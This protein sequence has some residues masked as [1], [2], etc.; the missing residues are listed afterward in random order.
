[1]IFGATPFGFRSK[2]LHP[3][4]ALSGAATDESCYLINHHNFQ[5]ESKTSQTMYISSMPAA[6]KVGFLDSALPIRVFQARFD[7]RMGSP[8]CG[9]SRQA[10][11]SND[12]FLG[13]EPQRPFYPEV[14]KL[15][16][17]GVHRERLAVGRDFFGFDFMTGFGGTFCVFVNP[18]LSNPQ[19]E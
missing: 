7:A 19:L 8:Q 11:E 16:P 15:Q 6:L 4:G 12:P 5:S 1:M 13:A 2:N 10:P 17:L 3:S 18:G 14:R 9:H